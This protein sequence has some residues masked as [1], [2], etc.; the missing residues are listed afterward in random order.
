MAEQE[1]KRFPMYTR[2]G[3]AVLLVPGKMSQQSFSL[4]R[5]QVESAMQV[6]ADTSVV[7]GDSD[8]TE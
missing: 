6:I 7:S 5:Q 1:K 4:L 8:D 2:D 3:D